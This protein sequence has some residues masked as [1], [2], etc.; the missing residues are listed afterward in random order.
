MLAKTIGNATFL[1]Y[2]KK[3]ILATD[4]W[5]GEDDDAY[6]GS[7]NISHKIPEEIKKD[8]FSAQYIWFSHGHPDHLNPSS[9]KRFIGKKILL[10]DHVG[11]RIKD[12]LNEQGFDVEVIPDRKWFK[13]SDKIRIFCIT[14]VIQD[15]VLLIDINKHLF[16]NLNDAGT[17]GCT[18]LV[19]NIV[20]TYQQTYLLAL[21]GYGDAD[22]IN[23]FDENGDF[24]EPA[25]ATNKNVGNGL[26]LMAKSLGIKNVI[27]F[28][29]FHTFQ[30]EDSIWARKYTTPIE[31]YS[32]GFHN[33]LNFIPPFAII[34]CI[35][36]EIG[37]TDVE[38]KE[39]LE[40]FKPEVFGDNWSDEL[41]TKDM[42]LI[43]DY[44]QRK[45]KVNQFASFIN[46]RVGNKDNLI[47]LQGKKNKG[48]TFEVPRGSLMKSIEYEIF[49]DLL[50]G[51]FMKT[52]LHNMKSLYEGDL[53]FYITK[54]ADNGRAESIEE[55]EKYFQEY[56]RRMGM[57]RFYEIFISN[58]GDL[59]KRLL[60]Q[61]RNSILFSSA[62]K[63]Y[64]SIK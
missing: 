29:S 58:A 27:P 47:Q 59:A 39:S 25:A 33:D 6:F 62:K 36:G 16:I 30:R 22:M 31:A 18:M 46:F 42:A 14:T 11:G 12:G 28:S 61:N 19:K 49:D 13:L 53:N 4:P 10:P 41:S 24:I 63:I 50:I 21:S 1:A 5:M 45:E 52:T 55:L 17:R 38:Y 3:C 34:D 48:I 54:F 56:N 26:S 35:T 20:K 8:I 15:A 43:T 64:Y 60:P 2:D 23:C 44:F 37:H 32:V 51:N 40:V 57:E 9:L 7:W